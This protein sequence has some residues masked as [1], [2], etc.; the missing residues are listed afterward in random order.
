MRDI[1]RNR[2]L[3]RGNRECRNCK[4]TDNLQIDHI[5]PLCRGGLENEDNMQVLC[6]T[7]N[8]KKGRSIDLRKYVKIKVHPEYILISRKMPLGAVP[9]YEFH[10]FIKQMYEENDAYFAGQEVSLSEGGIQHKG[11]LVYG[12]V[13][14]YLLTGGLNELH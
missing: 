11:L 3:K 9:S 2:I 8:L 1:V 4:T 14:F 10:T 13:D 6:R 12:K 5:I 7:C